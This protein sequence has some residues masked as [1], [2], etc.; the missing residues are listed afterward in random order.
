VHQSREAGGGV[1]E[2]RPGSRVRLVTFDDQRADED[3]PATGETASVEPPTPPEPT[4]PEP[5]PVPPS[6]EVGRQAAPDDKKKRSFRRLTFEYAATAVIALVVAFLVQAYVV[7]PYRVPTPSMAT[8]IQ[9]GDRVLID[10]LFYDS[11]DIDRGDIIVFNGPA[12]VA[13]QVLLKRVVGLPGDTLEI[14]DDVLYVNGEQDTVSGDVDQTE[15]AYGQLEQH[16][17]WALTTPYTVPEG[18][19][20]LMGDNRNDSFDSRYWGPVPREDI[21]GRAFAVYWPLSEIRTLE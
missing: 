2:R 9:P 4:P 5:T 17:E 12:A 7:K 3:P 16:P 1:S 6:P 11:R 10:R 13:N 18:H 14:V 19:Y 15:P 21:I 8:T 20:Y